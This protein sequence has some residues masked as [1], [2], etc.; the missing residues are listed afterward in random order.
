MQTK[1]AAALVVGGGTGGMR[2]ALGPSPLKSA[3]PSESEAGPARGA[4]QEVSKFRGRRMMRDDDWTRLFM[5]CRQ[6]KP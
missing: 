6:G 5:T 1:P 3:P 4:Q 2:A